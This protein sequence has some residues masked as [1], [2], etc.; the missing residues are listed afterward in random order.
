[1]KKHGFLILLGLDQ[2]TKSLTS[3]I[4]PSILFKW[5]LGIECIKSKGILFGFFTF[6]PHNKSLFMLLMTIDL[7][8]IVLFFR[9][10]TK[11]YRQNRLISMSFL[12]VTA[13]FVGN[14]LDGLILG[15]VRDFIVV[16]V[17]G[18]TN[19]SD[20][21]IIIGIL[22]LIIELTTNKVFRFSWLKPKS[23]RKE[24]DLLTSSFSRI[25]RDDF[26]STKS[27][28]NRIMRFLVKDTNQD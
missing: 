1:M 19:L 16:P 8:I 20:I 12:L 25:V 24:W 28:L 7:V 15:Y 11:E 22:L 4:N 2:I 21:L 3:L 14:F 27:D 13:G 18:G 26:A 10:Y 23:I 5:G 17:I 9:F 6:S